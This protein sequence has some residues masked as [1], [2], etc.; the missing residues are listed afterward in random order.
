MCLQLLGDK[1]INVFVKIKLD[2]NLIMEYSVRG[3]YS[4]SSLGIDFEQRVSFPI[5]YA[6]SLYVLINFF[7]VVGII[8]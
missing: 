8:A 5:F 6:V 4:L 1:Y 2:E 7:L 3:N